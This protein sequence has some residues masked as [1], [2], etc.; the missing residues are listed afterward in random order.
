[1]T[2]VQSTEKVVENLTNNSE[3]YIPKNYQKI[4][5]IK[6][7]EIIT[8]DYSITFCYPLD[9]NV[10]ERNDGVISKHTLRHLDEYGFPKVGSYIKKGD[11]IIGKTKTFLFESKRDHKWHNKK[12]MSY[13]AKVGEE[14]II[15]NVNISMCENDSEKVRTVTISLIRVLYL[16]SVL[17]E[18]IEISNGFSRYT[19]IYE[20]PIRQFFV[21]RGTFI[22]KDSEQCNLILDDQKSSDNKE[23]LSENNVNNND[24]DVDRKE[25]LKKK[26]FKLIIMSNS[27]VIESTHV[28]QRKILPFKSKFDDLDDQPFEPFKVTTPPL[29]KSDIDSIIDNMN[30]TSG[31]SRL[32]EIKRLIGNDNSLKRTTYQVDIPRIHTFNGR[33]TNQDYMNSLAKELNSLPPNFEKEIMG[34]KKMHPSDFIIDQ[35]I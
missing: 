22:R 6:S 15:S 13:F 27:E 21:P 19:D 1:M 33:R 2:E 14:G 25:D 26:N 16:D 23:H 3:S 4:I 34:L 32:N 8:N 31:K 24:L 10:N 11:C 30:L 7:K 5:E 28:T 20:Y 12:D 9:I 18:P 17:G 29:L 35:T